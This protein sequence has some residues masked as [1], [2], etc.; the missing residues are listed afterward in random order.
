MATKKTAPA[1][2]APSKAEPVKKATKAEATQKANV[3]AAFE[4]GKL[5]NETGTPSKPPKRYS[6]EEVT[7]WY[8][9]YNETGNA[10]STKAVGGVFEDEGKDG[11]PY[12]EGSE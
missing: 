10:K 3:A 2:A 12:V 11:G 4:A 8:T 1:K 6:D 9:G 7:Q 5:A